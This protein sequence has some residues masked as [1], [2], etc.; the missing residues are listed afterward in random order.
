MGVVGRLRALGAADG[1]TVRIGTTEFE[2]ID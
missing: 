2:F 1:D